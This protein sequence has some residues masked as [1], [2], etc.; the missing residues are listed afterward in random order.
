MKSLESRTNFFSLVEITALSNDLSMEGT[1]T[2]N[3]Y[4]NPL[5]CTIYVFISK[6]DIQGKRDLM[7]QNK[8]VKCMYVIPQR[9]DVTE[10]SC[11]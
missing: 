6:E 11:I 8:P 2:Q 5:C 9:Q 3:K 7:W 1:G 10:E 4:L